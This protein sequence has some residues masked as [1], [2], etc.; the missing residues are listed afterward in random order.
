MTILVATHKKYDF[1]QDKIYNPIHVG[2]YNKEEFGYLKDDTKDNISE[3]N[4]YFSE[5]TALYWAWKNEYFKD[6]KYCG[7]VHYRRYF[8]GELDFKDGSILSKKEAENYMCEFDIL[9]PKKRNYFIESIQKHYNHAHYA[10]DLEVTKSILSELYPEYLNSYEYIFQGTK[11]H[12]YNM[13]VMRVDLF[14]DYCEWIFSILFEVEKRIDI[15]DYDDYQKRVFGFLAERLFNVWTH[16][17]YMENKLKI[18]ELPVVN[19]EGENLFLKG[20]GLLRRKFIR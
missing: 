13:F 9:V 5:L 1:P 14:E 12:L 19:I 2:A 16:H 6:K 18:K 8:M 17:Q 4:P 7:L 15:T 3:K 11:L 10:K 20:I